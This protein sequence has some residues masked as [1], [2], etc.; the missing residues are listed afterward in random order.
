MKYIATIEVTILTED[1][2][3]FQEGMIEAEEI[4]KRIIREAEQ[5]SMD[6]IVFKFVRVDPV[7]RSVL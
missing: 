1:A 5:T 2:E 6:G 7:P 3:T 4:A